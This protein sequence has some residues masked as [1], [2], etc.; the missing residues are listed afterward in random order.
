MLVLYYNSICSILQTLS[1]NYFVRWK[2]VYVYMLQKFPDIFT[3]GLLNPCMVS[4]LS[5]CLV[6]DICIRYFMHVHEMQLI[7]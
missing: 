4:K 3:E 7:M 5:V 6:N 2:D 1:K